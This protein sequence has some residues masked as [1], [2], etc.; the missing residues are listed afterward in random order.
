MAAHQAPPSLG[1]S[2]QEH[3]SGLPFPSPMHESEK[4]KWSRSVVPDPQR[5]HGLQLPGSSVPGIFQ[6]RGLEWG[7]TAFSVS[8]FLC[9]GKCRSLG[10][11][12][13]FFWLF[14]ASILFFSSLNPLRVHHVGPLQGLMACSAQHPLSSDMAVIS[15]S[16]IPLCPWYQSTLLLLIMLSFTEH[17]LCASSVLNYSPCSFSTLHQMS[18]VSNHSVWFQN[19]VFFSSFFKL[20]STWV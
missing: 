10:L 9:M 15:F 5:L 18:Q 8:A 20:I 3:W 1:F 2:R 7:A 4:W 14:R 16:W 6:A 11:L 12:K 19:Y 13:L 17:M